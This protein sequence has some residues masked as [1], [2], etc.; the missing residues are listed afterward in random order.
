MVATAGLMERIPFTTLAPSALGAWAPVMA[1][2]CAVLF[3]TKRFQSPSG[4]RLFI[5]AFALLNVV[6]WAQLANHVWLSMWL[7][8]PLL[9]GWEALTPELVRTHTSRVM[10][11][12][13]VFAGLHKVTSGQYLDG[14]YLKYL[15]AN[16]SLTEQSLQGLGVLEEA[17]GLPFYAI[18]GVVVIAAELVIGVGFLAKVTHRAFVYFVL[19]SLVGLGL[20]ADEFNFTVINLSAFFIIQGWTMSDRVAHLLRAVLVIDIMTISGLLL[21]V[22]P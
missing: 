13:F 8:A 17:T 6:I 15:G 12:V 22:R 1:G 4:T 7:L 10:G 21:E 14:T 11:I 3:F 18:A 20:V 2:L 19:A 9:L 5:V 16:G